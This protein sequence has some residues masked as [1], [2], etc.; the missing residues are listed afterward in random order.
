M[1]YTHSNYNKRII[2]QIV[3]LNNPFDQDVS[4]Y[5]WIYLKMI[6]LKRLSIKE[7]QS[8]SSDIAHELHFRELQFKSKHHHKLTISMHDLQFLPFLSLYDKNN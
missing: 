8:L 2:K 7:L 5:A 1:D 3:K 4:I 6:N